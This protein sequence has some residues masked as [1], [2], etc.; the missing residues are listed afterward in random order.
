VFGSVELSR[1][2]IHRRKYPPLNRNLLELLAPSSPSLST[3]PFP[4]TA[5]ERAGNPEKRREEKGEREE[6]EHRTCQRREKRGVGDGKKI[7]SNPVG[8]MP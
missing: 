1:G 7:R 6:W 5:S 2:I 8:L 3:V 4:A